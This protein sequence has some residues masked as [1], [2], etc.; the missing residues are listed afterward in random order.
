MLFDPASLLI[1]SDDDLLVANKPAG[2]PTLV[3]GYHP[4]APYLAGILRQAYAPLWVVHRL[5]RETSGVIVFARTAQAHRELNRQF[6]QR[7]AS[8]V[9]HALAAGAPDWET[10]TC[11]LR[12]RPDGDRRHRTVVDARQ[13]KTAETAI[14]V[15]ERLGAFCLLE[16]VPHTGRTHQIRAHLAALGL[17]IAADALYGGPPAAE[18]SLPIARLALHAA[19]LSLLH[20]LDGLPRQFDAPYPPDFAGCLEV[21]RQ[22]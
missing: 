22:R 7:Q 3:D 17:P 21:L 4:Q 10:R 12:L 5:D 8:K 18:G 15:L 20:P 16:A 9:Y 2:L 1:W 19:R 14:R 13:G 11:H 6:E